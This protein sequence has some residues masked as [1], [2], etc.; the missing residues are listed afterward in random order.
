[1]INDDLGIEKGA[2]GIRYLIQYILNG[3]LE[4]FYVVK[5]C[6]NEVRLWILI[7]FYSNNWDSLIEDIPEYVLEDIFTMK[8]YG[9]KKLIMG[10]GFIVNPNFL[11][12][13]NLK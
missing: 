4:N 1:M 8:S 12:K 5:N 7:T 3:K 11:I 13:N 10:K 6:L 2:L 9:T